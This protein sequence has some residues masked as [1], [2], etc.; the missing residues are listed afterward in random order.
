MEKKFEQKNGTGV[1]FP[2]EK[3]TNENQP[4]MTGRIVT[5]DGIEY[6]LAAWTKEGK[7]GKFLKV[8]IREQQEKKQVDSTP[9]DL[10]F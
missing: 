3:R 2:N 1:L 7:N 5:P 8:A 10:T 4:N 9:N 6:Q